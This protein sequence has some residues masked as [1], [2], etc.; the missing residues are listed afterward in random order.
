[1]MATAVLPQLPRYQGADPE[2]N[3]WSQRL[4]S[5]LE[6]WARSLGAP[7]GETYTVNGTSTARDIDPAVVTTIAEVVDVLGTLAKDLARGA[8]LS[9]T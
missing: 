5:T 9:T 6:I 8:P 1:M 2:L 3:L 4:C 7:V